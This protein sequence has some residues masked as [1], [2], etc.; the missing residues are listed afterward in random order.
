MMI[1]RL[2][3]A[4]YRALPGKESVLLAEV[5]DHVPLLRSEGLATDRPTVVMRAKDGAIVQV[6]EWASPAAMEEAKKNP[7]VRAMWER[8]NACSEVSPLN[9]LFE[10]GDLFAEFEPVDLHLA[11]IVQ[12]DP[13]HRAE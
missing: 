5:R 1:P 9:T 11:P 4:A 6:F 7:R 10:S 12:P 3:V 13:D 2:V 8:F